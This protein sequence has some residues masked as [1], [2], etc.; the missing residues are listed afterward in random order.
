MGHA[1]A[2][3]DEGRGTAESKVQAFE[4]A[5]GPVADYPADIARLLVPR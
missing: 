5:G 1:G 2:I 4:A 3:I